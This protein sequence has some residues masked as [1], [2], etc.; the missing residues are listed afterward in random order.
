[1]AEGTTKA[2]TRGTGDGPRGATQAAGRPDRPGTRTQAAAAAPRRVRAA[3]GPRSQ[4]PAL[5]LVLAAERLF[6]MHGLDAVSLRHI[7]TAAGHGNNNAV[8]YHFGDKDGLIRAIIAY[9]LPAIDE[10]RAALL[11]RARA[12]GRDR[13]VRTLLDVLMRPLAAEAADPTSNYVGFLDRLNSC[14]PERHPWLAGGQPMSEVASGVTRALLELLDHLPPSL[15]GLR[16]RH[17]TAMCVTALAWRD[18]IVGAG[19]GE[20]AA[21]GVGEIPYDV[22]V[23]D[24]FDMAAAMLLAPSS[25]GFRETGPMNPFLAALRGFGTSH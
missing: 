6:A 16:L 13:D 1:M 11:A 4:E 3:R 22:F 2:G 17:A 21:G 19:G 25:T 7:G 9:R 10:R 8:Q 5:R 14:P 18:R 24:L 15:A 23:T 20:P 12:A